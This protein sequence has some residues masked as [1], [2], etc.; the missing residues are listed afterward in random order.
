[1]KNWQ[2]TVVAPELSLE[3]AIATLDRSALR[4]A[5][6]VDVEGRLLGT[7]TDGDIRRAL[8]RQLPMSTPVRDVMCT[9]PQ[10][11]EAG[12]GRERILALMQEH[13][14][15]H[16]PI[17]DASHRVVGLETLHGVLERKTRNNP[18]FVMAGGFGTRLHPLTRAC[19]KPMLHVGDRPILQIILERLIEMGF[20]RFYFSTHFMPEVI[21][22]HFGNGSKWGVSIDYVHEAEPLGTGGA[23]G[24]LPKDVI[25]CPLLM[26]NGDLLT[27][28]DYTGLLDFHAANGGVATMCAGQYEY[29][30]PY[31]VIESSGGRLISLVEKPTQRVFINAGIYVLSPEFLI[32]IHPG[33]RVD[34]PTLLTKVLE[35]GGKVSIFPI[36]EYWLDIGRL[37]DL[38]RAQREVERVLHG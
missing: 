14:L 21:R 22:N 20:H 12:W 2:S 35:Q 23:L 4:I 16:V 13:E 37:E 5:I 33:T 18:V 1:M 8:L 28:L 10:K 11:A 15:L 30:I 34:M 17:V 31:G 36:H 19:P 7:L 32:G 29:Q 3:S 26:V 24:L 27:T 9:A 25:D 6:V 38:H